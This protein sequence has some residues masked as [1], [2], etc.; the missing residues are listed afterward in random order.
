M[1]AHKCFLG[2]WSFVT[3][4][5]TDQLAFAFSLSLRA[6]NKTK[7]G[8]NFRKDLSGFGN[9]FLVYELIY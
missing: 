2:W 6:C 7:R 4:S 9:G 1:D 3:N 8:K 5:E